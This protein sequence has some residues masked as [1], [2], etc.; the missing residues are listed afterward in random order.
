MDFYGFRGLRTDKLYFCLLTSGT[1][2]HLVHRVDVWLI[3]LLPT[4]TWGSARDGQGCHYLPPTPLPWGSEEN[5]GNSSLDTISMLVIT[6]LTLI[7]E[8]DTIVILC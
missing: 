1:G 6:I 8:S 5:E 4:C 3:A 2:L 7:V